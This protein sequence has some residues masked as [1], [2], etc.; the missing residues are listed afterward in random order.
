MTQEVNNNWDDIPADG[1]QEDEDD[2]AMRICI[3]WAGLLEPVDVSPYTTVEELAGFIFSASECAIPEHKLF[4]YK[5]MLLP[6]DAVLQDVGVGDGSVLHLVLNDDPYQ[7]RSAFSALGRIPF[8]V[9]PTIFGVV[10]SSPA[11][12]CDANLGLRPLHVKCDDGSL[13]TIYCG[14]DFYIED[15][16]EELSCFPDQVIFRKHAPAHLCLYVCVRACVR[17]CVCVC[18]RPRSQRQRREVVHDLA[19]VVCVGGEV[20]LAELLGGECTRRYATRHA[21]RSPHN[22]VCVCVCRWLLVAVCVCPV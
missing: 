3:N 2:K 6:V 14:A 9:G 20:Q 1:L 11:H 15:I 13:K 22:M 16:K 8:P 4:I 17:V 7:G 18:W 19:T 21:L 10:R 5:G 12:E